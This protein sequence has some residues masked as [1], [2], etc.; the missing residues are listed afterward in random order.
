MPEPEIDGYAW[1]KNINPGRKFRGSAHQNP[2][3][4]D[5]EIKNYFAD[6][7]EISPDDILIKDA[8][9]VPELKAIYRKL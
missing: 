9:V 6:E 1:E 2:P 5:L 3:Y 8:T 4:T 7:F